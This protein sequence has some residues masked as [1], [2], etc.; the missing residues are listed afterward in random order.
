MNYLLKSDFESLITG[1][2][3]DRLTNTTDRVWEKAEKSAIEEA[4]SYMRNRYDVSQE[5]RSINLHVQTNAYALDDRVYVPNGDDNDIY[6]ALQDV[7]ATTV[8]TDPLFWKQTD[9]RNPKIVEV[10]MIVLLYSN[11][12]RINGSEIPAWLILRYDGGDVKQTGGVI[13]YLKNI[14]RGTIE[15]T[16]PL[17][18]DV[19]DGTTQTGNKIAYGSAS[20]AVD[21]NTSI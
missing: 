5:F 19:A 13:G 9:D 15:T 10:V 4:S 3:L 14:Q 16:V 1:E 6:I 11:Y 18:A 20:D 2:D 8:I 21:R 17:L 12:T 7:P